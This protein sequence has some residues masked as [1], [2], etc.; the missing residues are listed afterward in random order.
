MRCNKVNKGIVYYGLHTWSKNT[1]YGWNTVTFKGEF[2]Q[3]FRKAPTISFSCSVPDML[4]A[5]IKNR[6]PVIFLPDSS[7]LTSREN[8]LAGKS[9]NYNKRIYI[10]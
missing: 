1:K 7:N 6:I 5:W 9:H 8:G 4:T 3:I 2:L 10:I